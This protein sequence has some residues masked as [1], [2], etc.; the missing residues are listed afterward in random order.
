MVSL[1]FSAEGR[2]RSSLAGQL[3]AVGIKHGCLGGGGKERQ[4]RYTQMGLQ[5]GTHTN[6]AWGSLSH[7]SLIRRGAVSGVE[8]NGALHGAI[9]CDAAPGYHTGCQAYTPHR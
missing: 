6:L 7:H 9:V 1:T 2:R 4:S 3:G 8:G 5:G